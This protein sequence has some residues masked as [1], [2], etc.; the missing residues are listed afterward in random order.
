V[1]SD[2]SQLERA[3][4][5]TELGR[6]FTFKERIVL[7]LMRGKIK[8]QQRRAEKVA[9]GGRPVDG[10]AVASLVCGILAFV[11]VFTGVAAIV[12]GLVSLGRFSRD[13]QF[14]SGKGMAIAGIITGGVVLLGYLLLLAFFGAFSRQ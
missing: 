3:H 9:A 6:K 14:R 7:S 12:L 10:F 13:P 5:E 2:F 11:T 8:R 4:V 1:K